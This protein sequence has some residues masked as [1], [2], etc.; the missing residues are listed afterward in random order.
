[1]IDYKN[2]LYEQLHFLCDFAQTLNDRSINRMIELFYNA[3]NAPYFTENPIDSQ[4]LS[5]LVE[6]IV[7][8]SVDEDKIDELGE[9]YIELL[10]H[11]A[12][13]YAGIRK[14]AAEK[15]QSDAQLAD[16]LNIFARKIAV[17]LA[18]IRFDYSE[19]DQELIG[20][21]MG[22]DVQSVEHVAKTPQRFSHPIQ[23]YTVDRQRAYTAYKQNKTNHPKPVQPLLANNFIAWP[24][25]MVSLLVVPL[26]V[27]GFAFI[28]GVV[29]LPVTALVLST[30]GLLIALLATSFLIFNSLESAQRCLQ[31][32]EAQYKNDL[33]QMEIDRGQELQQAGNKL[34]EAI[35]YRSKAVDD[36]LVEDEDSYNSEVP[37]SGSGLGFFS[38]SSSRGALAEDQDFTLTFH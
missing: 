9:K 22:L 4:H 19:Q 8:I 34:L 37:R 14:L 5:D 17:D 3:L 2:D 15:Q 31:A 27:I 18:S 24:L 35:K 20:S 36:V 26:G 23:I 28:P 32:D 21:L 16:I 25:N 29:A 11:S 7:V 6:G 30:I 1:M 13:L 38:P 10:K 12:A 33:D